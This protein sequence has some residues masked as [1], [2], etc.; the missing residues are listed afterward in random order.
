MTTVN[1]IG[2]TYLS[3]DRDGPY[4]LNV[5]FV[6]GLR[7]HPKHTWGGV[8]EQSKTQ[9][10][11]RSTSREFFSRLGRRHKTPESNK[12]ETSSSLRSPFW[13]KEFLADDIPEARIWTYGYNAD[14]IEGIF[15]AS[16][17]NSISNHGRDLADPVVFIAHSLG[18]IIVK[19]IASNLAR[20]ALQDSN[21]KILESLEVNG[22]VLDNIQEEFKTIVHEC[23]LRIHSFQEARGP[24]GM[25]GFDGKVVDDFSSKVDLPR[26]YETVESIDADHR[27]M[28]GHISMFLSL[29]TNV[30]SAVM[31]PSRDLLK[32][33]LGLIAAKELHFL[34]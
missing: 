20:L 22:E 10:V 12:T 3:S 14:V 18:G 28:A 34:G 1:R 33:Y 17:K 2:F 15:R 19:D 29:K 13:P 5:I 30:S 26:T 8:D 27:Q 4:R 24:L 16:N 7:G 9:T 23:G 25:K 21:K 6:H 11:L 32:S 31:S